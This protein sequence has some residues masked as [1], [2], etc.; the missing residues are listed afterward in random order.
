MRRLMVGLALV[1]LIVSAA[2][3][4]FAAGGHATAKPSARP[5]VKLHAGDRVSTD[6][7]NVHCVYALGAHRQHPHLTCAEPSKDPQLVV[8]WTQGTVQVTR[9]WND[10][11]KSKL[12]FTVK[13]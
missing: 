9:C 5:I 10:C 4:G 3:L 7:L 6:T 8:E 12:L 1:A 2:A 11:G 13:R